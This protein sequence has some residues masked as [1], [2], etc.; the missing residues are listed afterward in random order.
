MKTEIKTNTK[1]ID[2]FIYSNKTF[3]LDASTEN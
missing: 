1:E 3:E 2:T